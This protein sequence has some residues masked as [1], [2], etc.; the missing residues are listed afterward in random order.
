[1][2]HSPAGFYSCSTWIE[3]IHPLSATQRSSIMKNETVPMNISA[4][5]AEIAR[6]VQQ[7]HLGAFASLF[8]S[9]KATVYSLCQQSAFS[10][11]DAEQL[12]QDIFLDAFRNLAACPTDDLGD[13]SFLA[14]LHSSAVNRI[15][16]YE[17]RM[18]L[19]A[20]FLDHLVKL[21]VEPIEPRRA[22]LA[23]KR[24]RSRNSNNDESNQ[25]L[26]PSW[27]SVLAKFIRPRQPVKALS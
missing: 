10:A 5:E 13:T 2:E 27:P 18:R 15:Q 24:V 1:M 25:S 23:D 21:A 12:T 6:L 9:H 14:R 22:P 8:D 11:P 19:S 4:S 26:W 16:I 3:E 7:G 20:P 17:R